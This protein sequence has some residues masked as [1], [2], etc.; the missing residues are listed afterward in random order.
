MAAKITAKPW[1]VYE[2]A[3]YLFRQYGNQNYSKTMGSI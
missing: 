3:I 2:G 1:V